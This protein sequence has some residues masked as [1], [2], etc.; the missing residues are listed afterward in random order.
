[1]K[2][3]LVISLLLI[4]LVTGCQAAEPEI[5]EVPVE[6]T[7]L[8]EVETA[9]VVADVPFFTTDVRTYTSEATGNDYVVY[10]TLP[11][12]YESVGHSYPVLYVTDGDF[13]TVPAAT[14]AAMLAAGHEMPEVITVGIGHGGSDRD[15]VAR[16]REDMAVDGR[17]SFL[18]FLEEELIPDIE[19]K[20]RANPEER[21][22]MGHSLGG[23]FALYALFNA[24]DTFGNI[25]A[26]S[27][28]CRDECAVYEGHGAYPSRLFVSMG[29]LD[30]EFM[31]GYELLNQALQDS[32][33]DGL[34]SEMVILNGET[35]MS[36]WP[37]TFTTGMKWVFAN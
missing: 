27:P 20:Y 12:S 28:S 26:S 2:K 17:E 35:H 32:D 7:R 3:S 34:A 37:R 36:A 30:R 22:L 18:E 1:M 8:V 6:V 15:F 31:P 33:Y 14:M 24:P 16:R 11:L 13:F 29:E 19:A 25:I 4:V 23:A 10:V 5:V 21:I 9:E